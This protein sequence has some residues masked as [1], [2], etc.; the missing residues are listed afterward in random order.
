MKE[1]RMLWGCEEPLAASWGAKRLFFDVDAKALI[2]W[3]S[4]ID[5]PRCLSSR[6]FRAEGLQIGMSTP[7]DSRNAPYLCVF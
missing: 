1:L 7:N 5:Q 6:L 4:W 2:G 3:R